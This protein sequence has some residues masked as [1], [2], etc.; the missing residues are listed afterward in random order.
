MWVWCLMTSTPAAA[1]A[2]TSARAVARLPSWLIPIS[3]MT[4]GTCPAP[5][6]RVPIAFRP[7]GMSSRL[8]LRA[9]SDLERPHLSIEIGPLNAEGSRRLADSAAVL[10]EDRR[11]VFLLEPR[12]RLLQGAAIGDRPAPPSSRTCARTS[13][14][15]MPRPPCMPVTTTSSRR[16]SSAALPRHGSAESS[17]SA[18]RD[19]VLG[20]RR[21]PAQISRRK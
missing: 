14:S 4:R 3:A 6:T 18:E 12:S 19:S 13:S 15:A 11:N 16:R 2:S 10:L 7:S 20:G 9:A 1:A 21:R 17:E 5:T 8:C